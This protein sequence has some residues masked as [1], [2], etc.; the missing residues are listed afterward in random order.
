MP[1]I[2]S[3]DEERSDKYLFDCASYN[4]PSNDTNSKQVSN[5]KKN[6]LLAK[7]KAQEEN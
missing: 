7:Q 3:L 5:A 1:E 6:S 2:P 4:T